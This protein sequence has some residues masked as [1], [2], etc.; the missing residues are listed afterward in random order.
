MKPRATLTVAV[1]A[2]LVLA[3]CSATPEDGAEPAG[4]PAAEQEEAAE[5][6]EADEQDADASDSGADEDPDSSDAM[7]QRVAE[8]EQDLARTPDADQDPL[9]E[10]DH[11]GTRL[12]YHLQGRVMVEGPWDVLPQEREGT[13]LAPQER[14]G[15]LDFTAVDAEGTVLWMAQRPASCAGFTL[16][17]TSGGQDL[18]ILTDLTTSEEALALTTASA[19]DLHTGE[20]VW[21]PV[22]VGGPH[23]GPGLV[24]SAPGDAPMGAGGP[25]VALDGAT[26]NILAEEADDDVQILDAAGSGA[27]DGQVIA[28]YDD[29]DILGEYDGTLLVADSGDVVALDGAE[30]LWRLTEGWG[31]DEPAPAPGARPGGPLARLQ[32]AP[33]AQVVL[34]LDE[35]SVLAE[36]ATDAGTD[37]ATGTH[38]AVEADH[39]RGYDE[40]G[41]ELWAY[42]LTGS[43]TITG[44]GGV[45]VYLRTG[46]SVRVHNVLT[47]EVAEAFDAEA[48]GEIL[49]PAVVSAGGANLVVSE[50]GYRLV[51]ITPDGTA[52]Q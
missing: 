38:V 51:T 18:A 10:V 2:A 19:Y 36:E 48:E 31:A 25:S 40:E 50:D 11:E 20:Q 35:G 33:E 24:F 29:A 30:E 14:D 34:D 27:E 16:T 45:M 5:Q 9:A 52:D 6:N 46:D 23:I 7:A 13:F 22:E 15:A 47:G 39:V 8:A 1:A 17:T 43:T 42:L 3:G 26:G 32:V 49:V 21:G 12:P 28:T 41:E 4:S 44:I 37:A